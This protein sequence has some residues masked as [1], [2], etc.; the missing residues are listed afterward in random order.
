MEDKGIL[1]LM[2]MEDDEWELFMDYLHSLKRTSQFDVLEDVFGRDK[3][4]MLFDIFSNE[5]I[6]IPKRSYIKKV[7]YKIKIYRYC[8][9]RG[10]SD[11]S[12]RLA[13]KVF[14]RRK[15]SVQR[16]IDK[17]RRVLKKTDKMKLKYAD[18]LG[19]ISELLKDKEFDFVMEIETP[20]LSEVNQ[21]YPEKYK[22]EVDEISVEE[23]KEGGFKISNLSQIEP[24]TGVGD[25]VFYEIE[26]CEVCNNI[27][28]PTEVYHE[29]VD[30]VEDGYYK[31]DIY[32]KTRVEDYKRSGQSLYI[33][34]EVL[35]NE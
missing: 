2:N 34:G 3:L 7:I 19:I 15:A 21:M 11:E 10:F 22:L 17:V 8:E 6:K 20:E 1:S 18:D 31:I 28:I 23:Y 32:E 5:S 4:L 26:G 25:I 14:D 12:K 30:I 9:A 27:H 33:D 16:A 24:F 35:D 13:A 29:L